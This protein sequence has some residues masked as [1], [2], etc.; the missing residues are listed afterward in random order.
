MVMLLGLGLSGVFEVFPLAVT[1]LKIVSVIY[2][3]WLAWKIANAAAPKERSAG[4]R[5]MTFLQAVLFQWVNPKAWAMFLTATTVYAPRHDVWGIAIVAGVFGVV[6]LPSVS[7]WALLGQE[8]RRFLSSTAAL[9]TFNYTMA[10][11]LILSLYPV[12]HL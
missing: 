9:R 2:M 7:T 10:V 1:L 8:M 3:L 6:N 4:A 11:L 12:L 5:P